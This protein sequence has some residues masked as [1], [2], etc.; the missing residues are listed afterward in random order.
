MSR[1]RRRTGT[2]VIGGVLAALALLVGGV[3]ARVLVGDSNSGPAA[4]VVAS[5]ATAGQPPAGAA[6]EPGEVVAY[7]GADVAWEHG[8]WGDTADPADGWQL[9]PRSATH[10]PF[11][12]H[13]DG[14][15][16]GFA[17][18]DT[19]ACLAEWTFATQLVAAPAGLRDAVQRD[20]T[21]DAAGYRG[22]PDEQVNVTDA[23]V[24]P[25]DAYMP[26]TAPEKRPYPVGCVAKAL[27]PVVMQVTMFWRM[28]GAGEDTALQ[29]DWT[30]QND[31]WV[32]AAPLDGD[33]QHPTQRVFTSPPLDSYLVA[34]PR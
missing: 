34:A 19:G 25:N 26:N 12:L 11:V 20:G 18:T 29:T 9:M 22:I 14:R 31:T 4:P 21:L 13:P 30:W 28:P 32:L 8:P 10:G 6:A 24:P 7:T 1:R 33:Y 23:W 15:R 27:S 17:K 5:D 16:S 3:A 2:W